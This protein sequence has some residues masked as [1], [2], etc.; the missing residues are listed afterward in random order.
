MSKKRK[1]RHESKKTALEK[2]LQDLD[3]EALKEQV[4]KTERIDIRL[5][6]AEKTLAEALAEECG[7][8]VTD[9]IVG[10]LRIAGKKFA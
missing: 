9:V 5:T 4:A 6:Q 10:L 2:A 8:N 7:G 3:A 1:P